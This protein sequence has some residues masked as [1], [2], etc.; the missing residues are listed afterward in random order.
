MSDQT[1]LVALPAYLPRRLQ[2]FRVVRGDETSY[3]L[4]DKLAS[5]TH[6]L[7]QWQFFVLEV[8]PGCETA[9]KLLSVFSD[10]FGREITEQEVMTFFAHLADNKL[11]DEDSGKH[12][13]LKPFTRTGY[14]LEQ[15]LI[16]PKSFEELAVKMAGGSGRPAAPATP[17]AATPDLAPPPAQVA[18]AVDTAV[19]EE[20]PAGVNEADNLDPRQSRMLLRLFPMQPVATGLLPV[21][22]PLKY[23]VYLIPFMAAA[24]LMLVFQ[25]AGQLSGDLSKLRDITSLLSHALFS[26]LTINLTVTV[27]QALVAQKFRASVGDFGIG[28]RFGFFPRF[29]VQIKHTKQL[30]RRERMWLQGGPLLMRVL[31]FSVGMLVWYNARDGLPTLSQGGLALAFLCAVNLVIEGGNPLVKGNGYHLLAAFVDE[32][33]LRAKSYRAFMSRMKGGA[34]TEAN[35]GLLATYALASFIYAYL[36]VL[37]IIAVVGH[38]LIFEVRLGGA[39]LIVAVALGVYLTVR[40]V[41]RFQMIS[42]AY[43]RSV[44]FER[45]R[46]RALPAESGETV[47]KE[48]EGSRTWRYTKRALLLSTLLLL[49]LPYPYEA[50]GGF[51]IFPKDRQVITTDVGGLI[52]EVNFDGGETITKGTVIA[53]VAATDLTAQL[54][55]MDARLAEQSATIAE[56]KARPKKEEVIVVQRDLETAQQRS[57][58]SSARVPRYERLYRDRTISFEEFDMVRREAE[59]DQREVAQREAALALVK[60]GTPPDKIAAEQAQLEGLKKQRA[61]IEGRVARTA[62][63]M[64]FDGN[65]LSLHLKQRLNSMLEKGTPFATVESVGRVTAQIEVPES[66]IGFIKV[67]SPVR[68]RANAF[69]DRVFEGKVELIDR[70][71]TSKSFSKVV[72][73]VVAVD[74][75]DG[76]LKTAMSGYAKIDA[77]TLPV[78]KAFSLALLRFFNVQVWSWVP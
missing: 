45:W 32:P 41:R 36:V 46:R 31:L 64:P 38:F 54:A 2:A 19:E 26:L 52:E 15:G 21:L 68:L 3:V 72:L 58:F 11:L 40:T 12:P 53:R 18:Q 44:Q 17:A 55:V 29:M 16:K 7:Q 1:K 56:L 62:M 39:G 35:E 43:D 74:N 4:R 77:G 27:T 6:D 33:Y 60:T 34:T 14:A 48:P 23:A 50:G 13:L 37:L 59:V 8:L 61:E 78:W 28:L 73:V 69:Y 42:R 47:Q 49:F 5:K 25:H 75:A 67:G 71:V 51:E 22:E 57:Q 9:E 76:A 63:R 30:S 65:I 10:R 66:D 70:N 24:A 20:L